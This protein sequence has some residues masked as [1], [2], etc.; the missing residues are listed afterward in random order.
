[1]NDRDI[2]VRCLTA[3]H[4]SYSVGRRPFPRRGARGKH[5]HSPHSATR[6]RMSQ[7]TLPLSLT[8]LHVTQAWATSPL[9]QSTRLKGGRKED[10][11]CCRD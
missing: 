10:Q 7:T 8:R 5:E 2:V 9:H 4:V 1:M 11:M 3:D 6:L